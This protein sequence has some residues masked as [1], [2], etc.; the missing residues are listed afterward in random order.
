MTRKDY[1]TLARVVR[2]QHETLPYN[3]LAFLIGTLSNE[4][5]AENPRFDSDRFWDAC[6]EGYT[7][8]GN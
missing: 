1:V 7:K 8:G 2:A 6:L 5:Q 3:A 4:L